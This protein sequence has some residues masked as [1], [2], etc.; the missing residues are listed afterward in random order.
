V[1]MASKKI[2]LHRPKSTF[3]KRSIP[4]I[5]DLGCVGSHTGV[6]TSLQSDPV[7]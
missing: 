5:N 3:I 2:K 6:K 7:G 4:G 1:R